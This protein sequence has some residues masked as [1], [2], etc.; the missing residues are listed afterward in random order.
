MIAFERPERVM[1]TPSGS[2]IEARSMAKGAIAA[3][4]PIALA[5]CGLVG[6]SSDAPQGPPPTPTEIALL[7]TSKA[8][9]LQCAGSPASDLPSAGLDYLTFSRTQRVDQGY[10]Q[11]TQVPWVG[12][13]AIGGK[14][15]DVAC[16]ATVILKDGKVEAV[17]LRTYPPQ[18]DART[19]ELC[20]PVFE[21]CVNQ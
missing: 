12:S 11:G 8:K 7:G 20:K 21:H 16:E 10:F 17:G 19:A 6:C 1:D 14:G 3:R 9:L 5:L 15:V 4:W 18:N 13:L 2:K